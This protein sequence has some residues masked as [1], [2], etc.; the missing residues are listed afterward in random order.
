MEDDI[1]YKEYKAQVPPKWAHF[2]KIGP[3]AFGGSVGRSS[4]N[5]GGFVSFMKAALSKNNQQFESSVAAHSGAGEDDDG[6]DDDDAPDGAVTV[7]TVG[8]KKKQN[9]SWME[10]MT[11]YCKA[12]D[13][14]IQ[15]KE[16]STQLEAELRKRQQK[17]NARRERM[18]AAATTLPGATNTTPGV[19]TTAPQVASSSLSS[20]RPSE[21]LCAAME[22]ETARLVNRYE[23]RIITRFEKREATLIRHLD[24]AQEK[25]KGVQAS[26]AERSQ[27]LQ[28][29][30]DD[31]E[32]KTQRRF[33]ENQEAKRKHIEDEIK[34][35]TVRSNAVEVRLHRAREELNL[36]RAE[37]GAE[38]ERKIEAALRAREEKRTAY[39][40]QLDHKIELTNQRLLESRLAH[41][42]EVAEDR[43]GKALARAQEER[44]RQRAAQ[45]VACE[46]AEKHRDRVITEKEQQ[47]VEL[48]QA[49]VDRNKS[50]E[51][52]FDATASR[53]Y[54]KT[55]SLNMSIIERA[56]SPPPVSAPPNYR[57]AAG[58]AA[59]SSVLDKS[60]VQSD[61]T[62]HLQRYDQQNLEKY[63][64][65]LELELEAFEHERRFQERQKLA[66][67]ELTE[68]THNRGVALAQAKKRAERAAQARSDRIEKDAII[69][70]QKSDKALEELRSM[71]S[72]MRQ[73]ANQD[74]ARKAKEAL[75][76]VQVT[77]RQELLKA[78]QQ[79]EELVRSKAAAREAERITKAAEEQAAHE[80]RWEETRAHIRAVQESRESR[81]EEN[82]Q[83][84]EFQREK[85]AQQRDE[86]TIALQ[87]Q[88][89][90][91]SDNR[92]AVLA[93]LEASFAA[94][95]EKKRRHYDSK[96]A[97]WESS[98]AEQLRQEREYYAHKSDAHDR[99]TEK[100]HA[101][102]DKRMEAHA[103]RTIAKL[104]HTY[105]RAT[106]T[107][108]RHLCFT[109]PPQRPHS[110]L[111]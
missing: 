107:L 76:L 105:E 95:R 41:Q 9:R 98:R 25:R 85:A 53:I 62:R 51:N 5:G 104:Q 78:M 67:A 24:Q 72:D 28:E 93:A 106:A 88:L 16:K 77:Q 35:S 89:Q 91:E 29:V 19:S 11:A 48:Q 57:T 101:S 99:R 69:R 4:R 7:Q 64:K 2:D 36:R 40:E 109:P 59:L 31:K 82:L 33:R 92:A 56:H 27:Y 12:Q 55:L 37:I 100:A 14:K 87:T 38:N 80:R 66:L 6:G 42:V 70:Q 10:E 34:A 84:K 46:R 61:V 44:S 49:W 15:A 63:E 102:M 108:P 74:K 65:A 81:L 58:A 90:T 79:K 22:L 94:K 110:S 45:L 13:L 32:R 60:H 26:L 3:A 86:K 17:A 83:K 50:R 68:R 54:D 75:E 8:G 43:G 30:T 47:H 71:E 18:L 23:E 21:T 97:A 73:T 52:R 96:Q 111:K 20:S 39:E 1:Q 103:E